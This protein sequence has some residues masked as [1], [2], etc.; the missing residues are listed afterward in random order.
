MYPFVAAGDMLF[1][2][3]QGPKSPE[4][5]WHVGKVG[6][7][8]SVEQAYEYARL[9]GINIL[10]AALS[11][12]GSLDRIKRIV[13]LTEFVNSVPTFKDHPRVI[14]G[15][16]DLFVQ[17]FGESGRHARSAVGVSSLPEDITVE[18][19]AILEVDDA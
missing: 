18:I 5:E 3:G 17:L 12:L 2:S 1:V 16:S 7:Q 9:A 11:A 15:C 19:E 8:V 4:G 10:A 13:K 14:N 6:A